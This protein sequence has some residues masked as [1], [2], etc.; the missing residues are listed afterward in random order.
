MKQVRRALR[1]L[2]AENPQF[3]SLFLVKRVH[4]LLAQEAKQMYLKSGAAPQR[5]MQYQR[6]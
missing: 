3:L 5:R 1:K 4:P 6:R 2:A